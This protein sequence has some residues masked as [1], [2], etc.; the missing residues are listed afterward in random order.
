[1]ADN[2][3]QAKLERLV[4]RMAIFELV[5]FETPC[6]DQRNFSGML[7]C[8]VANAPVRTTW[9]DGVVEDFVEAS[10][11]KITLG[12]QAKHSIKPARLAG[13]ICLKRSTRAS[14]TG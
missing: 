6:R 3:L 8:N 10:R 11:K 12:S 1:M 2:A 7:A 13:L 9:F 14:R 5:R 4:D